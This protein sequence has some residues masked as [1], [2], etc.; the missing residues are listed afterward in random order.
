MKAGARPERPSVERGV[1]AAVGFIQKRLSESGLWLVGAR[2]VLGCGKCPGQKGW[3]PRLVVLPSR[4]C[5][6]VLGPLLKKENM[7]P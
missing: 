6:A 2:P 7:T 1:H 5:G 3:S 4:L